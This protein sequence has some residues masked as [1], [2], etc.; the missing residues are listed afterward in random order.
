MSV[1]ARPRSNLLRNLEGGALLLLAMLPLSLM[2]HGDGS[3][4]AYYVNDFEQAGDDTP[5]RGW[6]NFGTGTIDR[7]PSFYA[8][9]SQYAN[10][11]PSAHRR[12]HARLRTNGCVAPAD[13]V[14]PYTTWGTASAPATFRP[15]ITPVSTSTSTWLSTASPLPKVDQR[16][17]WS[18][19]I[20]N[21]A[22]AHQRDFVFNAGTDANLIDG[23]Q[24][25]FFINASTNAFR[26]GAFPQNP[27]P[28]PPNPDLTCRTPV[29]ITTSGWYTL[30]HHFRNDG[31]V[32]A[33]DMSILRHNAVV[34][35]WT[36]EVPTDA[37]AL[38]GDDRYGWFARNEINDLAADCSV[39]RRPG[40]RHPNLF[41]RCAFGDDDEDSDDDDYD[42]DGKRDDEDG[43]DDGDGHRDDEDSDD[44]ND[45]RRDD[46]DSDDDND[47]IK[48]RHDSKSHRDR[49]RMSGGELN[50]GEEHS[51]DFTADA[52][53]LLLMADAEVLSEAGGLLA[54]PTGL[55]TPSLVVEILDPVGNVIASS[56]LIPGTPSVT[57]APILQGIHQVRISN[58]STDGSHL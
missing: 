37:I 3:G 57:A 2:A 54:N 58:R 1:D 23:F 33:V 9:P 8:S 48:D 56:A 27:C 24:P 49:Q 17:D 29:H 11:I 55:L 44:D 25:G 32:L 34:K 20:N 53:A 18:S 35:M 19:A 4:G 26:S 38:I 30:R 52:N 21:S 36:V 39:K 40:G 31:G 28:N 5:A 51:Y 15:C 46:E 13:C 45:D 16:F 10:R 47:G 43:D 6:N 50:P 14:G 7:T 42:S 41:A 12:F 22:G